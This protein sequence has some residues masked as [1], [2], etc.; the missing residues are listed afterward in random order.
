[1]R[2]CDIFLL[3]QASYFFSN[4][5]L[6]DLLLLQQASY[7]FI[8]WLIFWL[9]L[10][11]GKHFQGRWRSATKKGQRSL[12]RSRLPRRS[13]LSRMV[14]RSSQCRRH[15]PTHAACHRIQA[16]VLQ[17]LVSGCHAGV[18]YDCSLAFASFSCCVLRVLRLLSVVLLVLVMLTLLVW[19]RFAGY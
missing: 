5:S 6:G 19:F 1:M 12:P 18:C 13:A 10:F 14:C 7:I 2:C 3:E 8:S 11:S 16:D 9:H 4:M 15:A 17:L